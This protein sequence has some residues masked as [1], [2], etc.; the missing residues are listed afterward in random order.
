METFD[1][2]LHFYAGCADEAFEPEEE[3]EKEQEE[4]GQFLSFKEKEEY[5]PLSPALARLGSFWW[6]TRDHCVPMGLRDWDKVKNGGAGFM[7][8]PRKRRHMEALRILTSSL[9]VV[10]ARSRV[11]G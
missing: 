8:D 4:E 2:Q 3:D 9:V 6:C 10:V 1:E 7:M 11:F 5:G